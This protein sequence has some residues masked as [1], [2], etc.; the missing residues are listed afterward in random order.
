[1][2]S[3]KITPSGCPGGDSIPTTSDKCVQVENR[4]PEVYQRLDK[5]TGLLPQLPKVGS[6]FNI[7]IPVV[8]V[9]LALVLRYF[10]KK[11]ILNT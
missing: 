10:I 3:I 5:D 6:E 2:S 11:H 9:L 8:F 7:L 4:S 1:M